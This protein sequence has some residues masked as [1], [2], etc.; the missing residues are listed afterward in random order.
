MGR[1]FIDLTGKTFGSLTVIEQAN[2]RVSPNGTSRTMWKCICECGNETVVSSADLRN[3]STKSCGCHYQMRNCSLETR[4][5]QNYKRLYKIWKSMMDRCHNENSQQF[6]LYGGNGRTVCNE[7]H[8]FDNFVAWADQNGYKDG[9]TIDR[10]DNSLGYSPD[11]CRWVS[12]QVQQNNRCNNRVISYKGE[13]HTLADWARLLGFERHV[14]ANRL[15]RNWSVE[16]A[17]TT[18]VRNTHKKGCDYSFT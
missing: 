9:L 6:R 8:S 10:V 17:F 14:L 2:S 13:S 4:K 15:N 18:P 3:G 1:A 12:M 11:N 5:S 16:R 7:W